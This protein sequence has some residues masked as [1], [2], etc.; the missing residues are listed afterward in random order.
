MT[1]KID[2]EQF[3]ISRKRKKYRFALFAN[4][5]LCYEIG[6]WKRRKVD[7]L[8]LGAGTALFSVELATRHPDKT[9]IAVDVKA[10]RLVKGAAEAEIRKLKNIWFIRARADQVTELIPEGT[11]SS[12]WITFPD[13]FPRERSERRRMTH[14]FFL[15]FYQKVL[16][17]DGCLFL[18]HDNRKFFDWSVEQLKGEGWKI[19][20]ISNDLHQS[21]LDDD[22]K[23]ETSYEIR[24]RSEGLTTNFVKANMP[25][26]AKSN[27]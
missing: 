8:E 20:E 24:W 10:D 3:I 26:L 25:K 18:K 13:P 4:S 23:I 1:H 6:E 27:K 17:I 2:P 22:Y 7:V 9:F 14:P 21:E 16:K 19:A 15:K 11:L 5:P 12:L